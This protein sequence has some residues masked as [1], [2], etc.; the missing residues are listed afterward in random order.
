MRTPALVCLACVV[1]LPAAERQFTYTHTSAVLAPGQK[2]VEIWTTEQGGREGRSFRRVDTRFELEIGVAPETQV[3][4]YMNH[5]RTSVN[6]VSTSAFEGLSLE[7]KR[8]LS[9]PGADGLGS[10]LYLEGTVNASETELEAKAIVD[11]QRGAWTAAANATVEFEWTEE[12]NA[13]A[14]GARTVEEQEVKLSLAAGRALGDGWSLGF[15]IENRNPIVNGTWESSTLW[16]GPAV[17][18][19][20]PHLWGTLTVMPQITNLGGKAPEQQRELNDHSRIEA[21]LILGMHF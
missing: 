9:D 1:A 15:E 4:V 18:L 6:G 14:T 21:R 5:R 3:A 17:H 16:A 2:E 20:N 12:P 11:W 8:R 7:Y 19:S 13:N 10:A